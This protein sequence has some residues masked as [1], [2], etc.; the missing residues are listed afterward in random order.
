MIPGKVKKLMSH[1]VALGFKSLML[2]LM[3]TPFLLLA[4][5]ARGVHFGKASSLTLRAV[6]MIAD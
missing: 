5:L 3:G 6:D 1:S 4:D 2:S